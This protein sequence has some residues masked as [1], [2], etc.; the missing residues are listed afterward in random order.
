MEAHVFC[1]DFL[2]DYKDEF[3]LHKSFFKLWQIWINLDI[4]K[5]APKFWFLA[6]PAANSVNQS[7]VATTEGVNNLWQQYSKTALLKTAC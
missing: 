7:F 6:C 3:F 2:H 1:L 4:L 5:N